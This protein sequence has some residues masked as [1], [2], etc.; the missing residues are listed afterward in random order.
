[1][2]QPSS[3]VTGLTKYPGC[4]TDPGNLEIYICFPACKSS[5]TRVSSTYEGVTYNAESLR[6]VGRMS[7]L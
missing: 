5:H 6:T 2:G 4:I 1:M 7:T 3:S